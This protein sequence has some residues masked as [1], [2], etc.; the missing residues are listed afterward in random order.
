MAESQVISS[1]AKSRS[2]AVSLHEI[3]SDP[4]TS[5]VISWL[6][7]GRSW[8]ILQ[9]EIFEKDVIPQYFGHRNLASFMRQV[10]GWGFLR[11]KQG[12]DRK[13]YYHEVR[14]RKK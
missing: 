11:V 1:S 3:L 9:P 7:H 5:S 2:F 6:P 8:R 13:S 12:P 10:N 14:S 4:S